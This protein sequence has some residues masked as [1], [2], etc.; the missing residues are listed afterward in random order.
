MGII[1]Y[2]SSII[3]AIFFLGW[4]DIILGTLFGVGLIITG[5]VINKQWKNI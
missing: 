3:C 2:I 4:S 1:G 5:I